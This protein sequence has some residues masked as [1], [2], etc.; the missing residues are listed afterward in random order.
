VPDPDRLRDTF[1][2][3]DRAA[4]EVFQELNRIPGAAPQASWAASRVDRGLNTIRRSL[5]EYV[6]TNRPVPIPPR[7]GYDPSR[8]AT[9]ADELV[10]TLERTLDRIDREVGRSYPYDRVARELQGLSSQI[11]DIQHDTFNSPPLPQVQ[12]AWRGL[13][14]QARSA[15]R[16]LESARPPASVARAWDASRSRFD[17]MSQLLSLDPMF[18]PGPGP[19]RPPV[20]I[21]PTPSDQMVNLVD[22]AIGQLDAFLLALQPQ[23]LNVPEGFQF[24]ADAQAVR[25]EMMGLRQALY[26]PPRDASRSF[27]Q[28][29]AAYTRLRARTER[30]GQ[31]RDGP[32]INR[33]RAVGD[34]LNTLRPAMTGL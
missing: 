11:H 30:L 25:A 20:I 12:V 23:V 10:R 6:P 19:I 27:R 24:Q 21:E 22:Q 8:V 17:D 32:M 7:L 9:T 4:S 13:E 28:A 16:L 2:S 5:V 3:V 1:Q 15:G 14:R 26:S 29:E 34:V 31:G 33:V 18:G